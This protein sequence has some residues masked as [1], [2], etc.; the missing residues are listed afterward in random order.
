[1][2]AIPPTIRNIGAGILLALLIF[3]S[4]K[5]TLG[6]TPEQKPLV[7]Q[8]PSVGGLTTAPI[9][10]GS[11]GDAAAIRA[12]HKRLNDLSNIDTSILDSGVMQSLKDARIPLAADGLSP[13]NVGREDPFAPVSGSSSPGR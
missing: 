3:F 8:G 6:K 7:E 9:T 5:F 12:A 10:G 1:M 2:N 11:L 4:Y 13:E